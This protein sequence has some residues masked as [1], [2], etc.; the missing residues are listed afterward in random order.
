MFPPE[1]LTHS[2]KKMTTRG[3]VKFRGSQMAGHYSRTLM[4]VPHKQKNRE[5]QIPVTTH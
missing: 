4:K 5:T 1:G 3:L 2:N